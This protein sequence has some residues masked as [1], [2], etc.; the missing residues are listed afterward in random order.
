M[1][2]VKLL[3]TLSIGIAAAA[4]AACAS[5]PAADAAPAKA[6][7]QAASPA[8]APAPSAAGTEAETAGALEK[9]FQE[10]A[11][12]YK[13][14]QKD[15]KT[16]YCKREKRMGTTIPTMNCMTEA[17]LRNQVENMEEYRNRARNSSRCTHGA[18]CGAG[19]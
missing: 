12:S 13:T 19:G 6:P 14:V 9:R 8:S 5:Q 17:Q 10:A 3:Q 2:I 11:R 7:T 18:G 1:T 16:L 15:G 4:L